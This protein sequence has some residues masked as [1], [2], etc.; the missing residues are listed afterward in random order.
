ML[1]GHTLLI[2]RNPSWV[3]TYPIVFESYDNR[4]IVLT[5]HIST[6]VFYEFVTVNTVRKSAPKFVEKF[7]ITKMPKSATYINNHIRGRI[8]EKYTRTCLAQIADVSTRILILH[9]TWSFKADFDLQCWQHF[10]F[11]KRGSRT[12]FE[13]SHKKIITESPYHG[14]LGKKLYVFKYSEIWQ[15]TYLLHGW[16]SIFNKE[17]N[18]FCFF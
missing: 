15:V 4:M 2:Q 12:V 9:S 1:H 17:N 5:N 16:I 8:R 13:Y 14:I 10:G 11:N 18:F 7:F 6:R 3:W